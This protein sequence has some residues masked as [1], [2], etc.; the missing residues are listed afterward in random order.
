MPSLSSSYKISFKIFL[1]ATV[2]AAGFYVRSE[3]FFELNNNPEL[4]FVEGEPSFTSLD[5]YYYL[6]SAKEIINE[7]YAATDTKRAYPDFVFRPNHPSLLAISLAYFSKFSGISLNWTAIVLP[8]ILGMCIALP[9]YLF[10][11][12]LGPFTAVIGSITIGVLSQS[13]TSRTTLGMIDTDCLNVVFPL[14]CAYLFM[15]FGDET[16]SKRYLYFSAGMLSY[17]LFFWWWD[18]SPAAVS[19]LSLSP[20]AIALI[21][22]YRPN[23]DEA[24]VFFVLL[25]STIC[26][27]FYAIGFD[28][29]INT[30]Q[31]T[32]EQISYISKQKSGFFPNIGLSIEEQSPPSLSAVADF[33]IT[34]RASLVLAICGLIILIYK[35]RSLSFYLLPLLSIGSLGVFFAERFLIFLTPVLA[36]G[37]GYFI[38]EAL[39]VIKYKTFPVILYSLFLG[40]LTI[41]TTFF[42]DRGQHTFFSGQIIKGMLEIKNV[43]PKNAVIWSWWDEGHPLIYWSERAT[44]SDGWMHGGLLTYCTALPLAT[45]DY[46]FAA[47]FIQFYVTRGEKGINSFIQA[48]GKD[49]ETGINQLKIILANGP[50]MVDSYLQ[51]EKLNVSLLEKNGLSAKEYFFP[52]DA[53]PVFVFLDTRLLSIQRWIHWYGNWNTKIQSGIS[54]LPTI[55]L[56]GVTF[57]KDGFPNNQDYFFNKQN[58]TFSL[59]GTFE[60][61]AKITKVSIIRTLNTKTITYGVSSDPSNA[62]SFTPNIQ[63][64]IKNDKLFSDI[65]KYSADFI[66]EKKQIILRDVQ[67]SDALINNLYFR[68]NNPYGGYFHPID[69]T[70][71][72]YQIWKVSPE[73]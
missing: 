22:H 56:D 39:S 72:N 47:N 8:I 33:A 34:G 29:I 31:A 10:S 41:V 38:S 63:W 14:T 70:S 16:T 48:V 30:F 28:I 46:R 24:F 37:F 25:F 18:M 52:T 67:T 2:L 71:N 7:T 62:Y 54:T 61:P 59:N 45:N 68:K 69:I 15:R 35:K 57:D 3:R 19:F 20:L 5:G 44:I 32:I 9:L 73:H 43:T 4:Y 49:F 13:Y 11:T 12:F 51:T 60:K 26:V 65:G 64:V 50:E 53:P 55:I 40:F 42:T 66:P 36:I 1:I 21:F 6:Q 27:L 17:I 23:K 58:G